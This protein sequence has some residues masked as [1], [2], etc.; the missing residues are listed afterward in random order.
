MA[1]KNLLKD[2]MPAETAEPAPPS[3]APRYQKGAIGAVSKSIADL[4]SRSVVDLDPDLITGAGMEDRLDDDP[5]DQARLVASIRDHGQQVPVLVRPH[6]EDEDSYQ[7]VYGRR[8]VLALRELGLPVKAMIRDLDDTSLVMAQGQENNFRKDLSFI[9]K[10]NFAQQ[11]TTAGYDRKAICEA[12]NVDK[13]VISRMLGIL[14]ALPL[15][16]IRAIGAAPT[17]GRDRWLEL[18]GMWKGAGIKLDQARGVIEAEGA[19][20]SDGRFQTLFQWLKAQ[21]TKAAGSRTPAPKPKA[22]VVKSATGRRLARIERTA[23]E[24]TLT[25][26]KRDA[27]GFDHWLAEN[28]TELHRA[29]RTSREDGAK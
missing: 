21:N 6:P 5:E 8:R 4:K 15:D 20:T 16:L 22:T 1:R 18:S 17:A 12:L 9:E 7:I 13:T 2:L 14:D 19:E 29:W 23:T 25:L 10:A 11:M 3:P 28:L 27:D 26:N 24:T